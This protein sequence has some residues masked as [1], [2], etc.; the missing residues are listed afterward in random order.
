M[1]KKSLFRCS[2]IIVCSAL[3]FAQQSPD[4]F[5]GF[6]L[7]SD[8][9]LAATTRSTPISGSSAWNRRGSGSSPW[10]KPRWATTCSWPSSRPPNNLQE[11]EKYTAITRQLAQAEVDP[12]TAEALA[13][14][15]K[16]IVFVT[17]NLHSH[18]D[19]LVA[20]GHGIGLPPGQ[21]RHRR[22]CCDILDN[23]ILVLFP[24]VNPD[25]Q[26]MEVDWYN[27][28]KGTE[29]EG[30]GVP[31]LY[32][33]YAG[34]DDNRDWFKI[35]LKETELI[36]KEIYR[37]WFPQILVDEHQMGSSGDRLFVPPYQDP[38]TPGVHPLVWRTINLIGSR[39]GYD[40][41]K[42]NLQGRGFARF[43]H[44]LVDRF[45]RRFGLVP[46]H[47]GDSLRGR[48]G[49]PGQRRSISSPRKWKAPR[50]SRMKNGFSAPIPG[51][52][53]GGGWPTW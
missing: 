14:G 36:V 2:A 42:Q 26:I 4:R 31:Y 7:G 51:K 30:T 20:D 44:R 15:G 22:K 21:R 37:K 9:N 12:Q 23:V 32:H 29:Y 48:V 40:L 38:P 35:S 47:P 53:A 16:A 39:I 6:T 45:A 34:H 43:F 50:V 49:A 52:A 11:L 1:M 41:E 46:Q 24:S 13:A 10:A 18:R 27:K 5:L 3:A 25:G 28:T 17:C 33:W 19:R 8:R